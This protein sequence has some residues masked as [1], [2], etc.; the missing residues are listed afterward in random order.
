MGG[1]KFQELNANGYKVQMVVI[2][3]RADYATKKLNTMHSCSVKLQLVLGW[4]F[5]V[6]K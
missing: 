3:A 4:P 1:S 6:V 5:S 2:R